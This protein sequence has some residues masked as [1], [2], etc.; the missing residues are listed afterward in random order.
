MDWYITISRY[1][2][3]LELFPKWFKIY[4]F[5]RNKAKPAGIIHNEQNIMGK[6]GGGGGIE[7]QMITMVAGCV[8][9][10]NIWN[11]VCLKA[12]PVTS[13]SVTTTSMLSLSQHHLSRTMLAAETRDG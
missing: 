3:I 13:W 12:T 4:T 10:H 7:V 11:P 9:S 6:W 8:V 2:K 1:L 5:Y